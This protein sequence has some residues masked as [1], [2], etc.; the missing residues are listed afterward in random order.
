MPQFTSLDN[1]LRA[2]R[3]LALYLAYNYYYILGYTIEMRKLYLGL[4][5]EDM[6]ILNTIPWQ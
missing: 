1:K 6:I 5:Y 4:P 3:F 2:L